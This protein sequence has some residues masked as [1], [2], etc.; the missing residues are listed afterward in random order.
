MDSNFW[1]YTL[2]AIPQTLGAVIALT[3]TFIVFKYSEIEKSIDS[4]IYHIK[5]ILRS[6]GLQKDIPQ[7]DFPRNYSNLFEVLLFYNDDNWI[8]KNRGKLSDAYKEI[9]RD[10]HFI[11]T[12]SDKVSKNE[13]KYWLNFQ[14]RNELNRKIREKEKMFEFL[15]ADLSLIVGGI[16]FCI[17]FIPFYEILSNY[18]AIAVIS[19]AIL[20]AVISIIYTATIILKITHLFYEL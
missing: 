13:L 15:S 1:F 3:A 10:T 14:I 12:G 20:L 7:T 5:I 9:V 18:S 17:F 16:I 2:S 8:D 4:Q 19:M 11:K 6:L